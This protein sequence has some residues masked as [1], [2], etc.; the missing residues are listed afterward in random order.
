MRFLDPLQRPMHLDEI[1]FDFLFNPTDL[2]RLARCS[3]SRG[4]KSVYV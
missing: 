1:Q 2:Q 3:C 4:S